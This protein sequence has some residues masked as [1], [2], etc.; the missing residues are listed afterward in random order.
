M[1]VLSDLAYNQV[2]L[3]GGPT[4]LSTF[5]RAD[6]IDELILFMSPKVFA[7]SG[8]SAFQE[9]LVDELDRPSRYVFKDV[10][11]IAED[12]YMTLYPRR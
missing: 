3:E 11:L 8:K 2:L 5:D 12:V 1:D 6:L 4:M 9:L 7:C 10:R